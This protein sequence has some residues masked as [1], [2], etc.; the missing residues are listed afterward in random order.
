MNSKTLVGRLTVKRTTG[1]TMIIEV[2][3][4][5]TFSA[6]YSYFSQDG[7]RT[8]TRQAVRTTS[9]NDGLEPYWA[10]YQMIPGLEMLAIQWTQ[11]PDVTNVSVKI[12]KK[13]LYQ[14]LIHARPDALGQTHV[15]PI[16]QPVHS[17]TR[18]PVTFITAQ[19]HPVYSKKSILSDHRS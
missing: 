10:A 4:T 1:A 9:R 16:F 19:T 6:F 12:F 17:F 14:K 11:R 2:H 8:S 15:Q 5:A 18:I 7:R 3:T 13:R